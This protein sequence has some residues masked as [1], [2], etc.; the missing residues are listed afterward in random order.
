VEVAEKL[1]KRGNSFGSNAAQLE[2]ERIAAT[3]ALFMTAKELD[4]AAEVI[5]KTLEDQEAA[6]IEQRQ[7][8]MQ[9]VG[10][11]MEPE[12]EEAPEG[13]KG[14]NDH[15]DHQAVFQPESDTDPVLLELH[16]AEREQLR[17]SHVHEGWHIKTW[18]ESNAEREACHPM[19]RLLDDANEWV[20]TQDPV[21]GAI[22]GGGRAKRNGS[23][24]QPPKRRAQKLQKEFE[25]LKRDIVVRQK[26]EAAVLAVTQCWR[27]SGCPLAPVGC[28]LEDTCEMYADGTRHLLP[29]SWPRIHA[30]VPYQV[31]LPH[32]A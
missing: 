19:P 7:E 10:M 25:R 6:R 17:R 31:Q 32:S 29:S 28:S 8:Q 3:K 22:E 11:L 14:P 12:E 24:S 4:R 5:T 20:K 9:E 18:F 23:S 13:I 30:S 1:T 2:Q 27:E 16:E 21:R 26:H 15:N